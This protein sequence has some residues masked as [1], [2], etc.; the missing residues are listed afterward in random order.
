MQS[1]PPD[2]TT[3]RGPWLWLLAI[4]LGLLVFAIA[5]RV[6]DS[7]R[8]PE[9]NLSNSSIGQEFSL[10]DMNGQPVTDQSYDGKWRLMYFGYTWCPD[11]C[12]TDTAAMAAAL[13]QLRAQDA[14]AAAKLQ[15]LFVTVDPERDTPA[16]LRQYLRN[17]D[18]QIIGLTGTRA[19][20]DAL[21]K[22][23]RIYA[24]KVPGATPDSYLYDH[25]AM[26]Y[27]MDP[28]GRPV[29]FVTGA[30]TDAGALVDMIRHFLG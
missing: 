25:Q 19:Q 30:G 7:Q 27:L 29:Q 11:I 23:F 15:P 6:V 12:P 5:Y 20:V 3:R 24:A 2:N 1:A 10:T 28:K 13:R 21:L 17:F 9:G 14:K 18:P 26:F 22:T 4:G 8:I 16:V